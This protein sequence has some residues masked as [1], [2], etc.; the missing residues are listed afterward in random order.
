MKA[1]VLAAT[2]AITWPAG[3]LSS[4]ATTLPTFG[5]VYVIVMENREYGQIIG[6]PAA[7]YINHLA[8]TYGLATSYTGVAHPSFPNYLALWSG[9]TQGVTDDG[10]HNLRGRTIADQME[11]AGRGWHVAAQNFPLNC[12]RRPQASGGEDGPG[13]YVRKHEPAIS[14]TAV[15]RH[16]RRCARI[17]DFS[18]LAPNVGNLWLIVPNMC[19]DMHDCSVATGDTF[20]KRFVPK[21]L[22]STGYRNQTGLLVITW[23]EGRTTRGGGGRVATIIV[24]PRGKAAYR[25]SARYNHYSLLRTIQDS[26]GLP[27]L[28]KSCRATN[29]AAFFH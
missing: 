13:T 5:H 15:S 10:I 28:G 2:Y 23:D 12:Y 25:S 19:N 22:K 8:N 4:G 26:W 14:F 29:L 17:T 1:L 11:A 7:P 20:L 27:C 24:S 6:N 3:G 18:H 16:P 21:I 9:S